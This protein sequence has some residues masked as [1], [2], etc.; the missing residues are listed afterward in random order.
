MLWHYLFSR[1]G[2]L[3]YVVSYILLY[4][5]TIFAFN[6]IY[7]SFIYHSSLLSFFLSFFLSF[8]PLC[9]DFL[10]QLFSFFLKMSGT[11]FYPFRVRTHTSLAIICPSFLLSMVFHIHF[12][13]LFPFSLLL[14][15][16]PI[17]SLYILRHISFSILQI[18]FFSLFPHL[19]FSFLPT[20]FPHYILSGAILFITTLS[21]FFQGPKYNSFL[22]YHLQFQ[23][24][25]FLIILHIF[26]YN[27]QLFLLAF[28]HS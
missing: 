10:L 8:H 1:I 13:L 2:H 22:L 14:S 17:I 24:C 16:T 28:W 9:F 20:K 23:Q 4:F 18:M 21:F 19:L 5:I 26:D 6:F 15:S 12:D 3:S 11:S 7:H 27:L 25:P